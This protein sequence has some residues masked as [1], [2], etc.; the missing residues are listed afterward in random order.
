[1]A[2]RRASAV[3]RC[4]SSSERPT[5]ASASSKAC[6]SS[7]SWSSEKV[8]ISWVSSSVT[9]RPSALTAWARAAARR[10]SYCCSVI[11]ARVADSSAA[12]AASRWPWAQPSAYPVVRA[13]SLARSIASALVPGSSLPRF[14]PNLAAAAPSATAPRI[15]GL[16][17]SGDELIGLAAALDLDLAGVLERAD[18][19]DDLRLGLLDH[20]DL[21]RAEQVDL[22]EQIL[23]AALGQ[24]LGDLVAH[25]LRHALERGG[26]IGR[27]DLPQ[28]Q[29]HGAVLEVDDVLEHEHPA[30]D[31]LGQ[32]GAAGVQ[33]L[34]DEPLGGAV[35]PVD[36][37]H[38]RLQAADRGELVGLQHGGELALQRR[39]DLPD[40][41]G[42]GAVHHRDPVRHLGLHLERETGQDR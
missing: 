14:R 23:P 33:G 9:A 38:E 16:R 7:T 17:E 34:Q 8:G 41:L 35:G 15:T 29:L 40:D 30:P 1:M 32:L 20:L 2:R 28:H 4:G 31:L 24:V 11:R 19:R 26:Q 6:A 3:R 5:I 10:C 27:L 13:C 12:T 22:L 39:L 36:D 37:L 42:G 25:G 21:D 18:H